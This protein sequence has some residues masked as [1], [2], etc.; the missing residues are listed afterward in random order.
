MSGVSDAIHAVN[1]GKTFTGSGGSVCAVAGLDLRVGAGELF[2]LLGPNGAG[3]ST[4][5][6]ML[7]TMVMPTSGT[8]TVAGADVRA[9]PVAVK[10]RIGVVAQT[11]TL[12]QDL[13]VAE[14]FEYR[15]RFFGMRP[16][17][18]R[19]RAEELIEMFGLVA[20][21]GA[22]ASELSGGQAQRA[23]IARALMHL[24]EVLFLDEPT[25]GLDP[26]SRLHLWSI[27]REL[28]T[29]GQTILLTT[30]HMDEAEQLCD[31]IAILDHGSLLACDTPTALTSSL[32][33][34]TLLQVIYDG[35]PTPVAHALGHAPS[36]GTS[37]P[38]RVEV[39]G[40]QLRL[41]TQDPTPLLGQVI[42]H[43]AG[44]GL[45]VEDVTVR[46]PSLETVFLTLTG[47]EYRD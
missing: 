30:H 28:H 12:D 9:D 42:A 44:A 46:R 1:L 25:A 36:H 21:A 33:V 23:M 17:P 43:G 39:A 16:R 6:G 27:L 41:F 5:I 4:T 35:D 32:G 47:R 26:Q 19:R 31:R 2:G 40:N 14:N 7:T 20:R 22:M 24:P 18:A 15:G 3:K 8:A 34:D 10:R 13:S 11:N 38:G 37:P 29:H 45:T